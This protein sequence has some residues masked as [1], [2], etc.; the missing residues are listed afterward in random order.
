MTE[1]TFRALLRLAPAVPEGGFWLS[2]LHEPT[3]HPHLAEFISAIPAEHRRKFWFTTNLARKLPDE[4]I[5]TLSTSGLHHINISL[6]TFK[7]DLFPVLRKHGRINTFRENLDRLVAACR[8]SSSPPSLRYITMAFRSNMEEIPT[9]VRWMNEY[10][11]A[12]EI[13]IRYT[14]NTSNIAEEFKRQQYLLQSDWISLRAGLRA[15]PFDNY[16]LVTP[17]DGHGETEPYMPANWFDL[18]P[19]PFTKAAALSRPLRLRAR[20]DG[21]LHVSGREDVIVMNVED[22]A[23]PVQELRRLCNSV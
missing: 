22:F 7:E 4:L 5:D 9:L 6:D 14:Y 16:V 3:L 13:E 19:G 15:Q 1:A 23:E 21:R 12:Q 8:L 17:P 2:C 11:A 10:G 20:P 18:Y